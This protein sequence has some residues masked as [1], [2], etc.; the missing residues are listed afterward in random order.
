MGPRFQIFLHPISLFI[1]VFSYS[2]LKN[3]QTS[4]DHKEITSVNNLHMHQISTVHKCL[5]NR[6]HT[7]FNIFIPSPS[8]LP[9]K[10]ERLEGKASTEGKHQKDRKTTLSIV[11]AHS[12]C[13]INI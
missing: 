12:K 9:N 11:L 1:I 13:S 4:H 8:T 5:E 10:M 2:S 6:N 7:L 3:Q